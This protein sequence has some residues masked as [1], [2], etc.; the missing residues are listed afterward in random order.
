MVMFE[1]DKEADPQLEKFLGSL[2]LAPYPQPLYQ[3]V[4]SPSKNFSASLPSTD[5]KEYA[6]SMMNALRMYYAYDSVRATTYTI[7]HKK[8]SPYT[9]A[10]SDTAFLHQQAVLY[11]SESDSLL[12]SSFTTNGNSK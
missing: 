2:Q 3:E 5:I 11:R 4:F 10:K 6:D 7:T 9:W 8:L 1:K 12:F